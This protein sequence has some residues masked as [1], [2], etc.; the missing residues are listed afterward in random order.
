MDK[1]AKTVA[2]PSMLTKLLG[3]CLFMDYPEDL[4]SGVKPFIL[5]QHT[6]YVHK[7]FVT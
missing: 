3:L 4:S 7:A 6:P 2:I 5:G 1:R